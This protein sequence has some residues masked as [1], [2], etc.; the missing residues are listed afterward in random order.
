MLWSSLVKSKDFVIGLFKVKSQNQ[1]FRLRSGHVYVLQWGNKI[2]LLLPTALNKRSE[3]LTPFL[4][5]LSYKTSALQISML[6]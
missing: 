4:K 5:T 3:I 1:D 2:I 6:N